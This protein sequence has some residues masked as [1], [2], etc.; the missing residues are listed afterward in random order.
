VAPK[1]KQLA[2]N[3]S[4]VNRTAIVRRV[5]IQS[6]KNTGSWIFDLAVIPLETKYKGFRL[7]KRGELRKILAR[8]I[9]QK[10]IEK[11]NPN[12]YRLTQ[13]GM[14]K[15]LPEIKKELVHDGKTRILVFDVPES[16]RKRRDHFRRHLK[17]LGFKKHQQSVWISY[18]DCEAWIEQLVDYH[19]VGNY[20]SLYIGEHVW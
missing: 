18:E 3:K 12:R 8:L 9:Y 15:A 19:K 11:C 16:E 6:L 20:V 5:I 2:A 7:A 4:S 14:I 17:L 10:E 1:R 13:L